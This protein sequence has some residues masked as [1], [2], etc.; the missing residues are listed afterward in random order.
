MKF[1]V[2]II[3]LCLSTYI[4]RMI[5]ALFMDKIQVSG[6]F[7]TFLQ[8]I[9]YTAMASLVFPAILYVDDN[10]WVGIIAGSV[11]AIAAL[12]KLPIIGV[13]LL[14]VITCLLLYLVS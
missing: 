5:P 9:P 13:V 11:V 12:K 8:L 1:V 4:P 6:R 3:F 10:M 2:L 14:S 7:A